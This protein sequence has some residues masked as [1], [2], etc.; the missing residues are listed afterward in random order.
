[1]LRCVKENGLKGVDVRSF[2]VGRFTV[3]KLME[4]GMIHGIGF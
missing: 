3:E 1:M 2:V 4:W